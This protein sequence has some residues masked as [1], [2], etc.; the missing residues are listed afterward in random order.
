MTVSVRWPDHAYVPG[1][2][3]RHAE[4]VFDDIRDTAQLGMGVDTLA[5]SDAFQ[6]GLA[7]LDA[8]FYWEAHE[9]LEPVWMALPEQ[10]SERRF[11]QAVIQLAN[12]LLKIRMGRPKAAIRLAKIA[13]GLM[14][15]AETGRMLGL[16]LAQMRDRIDSLERSGIGAL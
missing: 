7:Y 16:D 4:G 11:V 9:V 14:P 10:S 15:E 2:N 13:R 5:E 1:Q 8:G 12:G 6:T 3:T